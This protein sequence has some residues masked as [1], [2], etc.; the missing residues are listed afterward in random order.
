MRLDI[1]SASAVLS[2]VWLVDCDKCGGRTAPGVD[3]APSA[4]MSADPPAP[5]L[6][7]V[8]GQLVFDPTRVAVAVPPPWAPWTTVDRQLDREVPPGSTL[9]FRHPAGA[10][11]AATATL[12]SPGTGIEP[13]LRGILEDKRRGYGA[14]DDVAWADDPIR[15]FP[16]QTLAFT[17]TVASR[18]IR[19][20]VWM[21]GYGYG[22]YWVSFTCTASAAD[23]AEREQDC[24]AVV[25]SFHVARGDAAP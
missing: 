20:K 23:F 22:A 1:I 4:A 2:F 18:A 24:R 9:A 25:A 10:Y 13:T 16:I 21:L 3:A 7:F 5:T 17:V 14:V 11:L 12:H 8:D 15:G 6:R 19:L